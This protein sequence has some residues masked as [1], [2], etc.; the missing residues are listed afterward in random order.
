M[1]VDQIRQLIV[2]IPDFPEPG[3]LFRGMTPVLKNPRALRATVEHM[4]AALAEHA[5]DGIV[6]IESLGF[7]LGSEVAVAGFLMELS[8]LGGG[9]RLDA[10][11][12]SLLLYND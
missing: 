11:V 10:P 2:E 9:Q 4:A 5:P 1:I 6:A 8:A 12:R 7:L 3:I